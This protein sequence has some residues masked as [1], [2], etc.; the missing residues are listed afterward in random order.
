MAKTGKKKGPVLERKI[1]VN[2]DDPEEV[3]VCLLEGD[4]LEAYQVE[5]ETWL[6]TRGNIYKGRITNIEPGLQAVFVDIGRARNAYLPLDDI[7]PD[8]FG[9]PENG[10]RAPEL[11]HKG[12]EIL[13]QIVKEESAMKGAAVTTYLSIPG[14]FLVIMPGTDQV[15]VSRKIEEEA[16]R[17]RLKELLAELARPEGIGLIVRT[18]S[19]GMTKKEIKRDLSYLLRLW[20]DLKKKAQ[21]APTP[22]L[23]YAERD[24]VTRFLRD[25]LT[26][27]VT[28]IIIDDGAAC[29]DVRAFLKIISP[30]H[31]ATVRHYDGLKPI[32]SHYGVEVQIESIFRRRVELPSGGSLV[33][34]PT[35][36]LVA[37]DVNSGRL[38]HEKDFEEI[39]Y[40][41][42]LEAAEEIA[43]QLRL[44]DL[45]GII[46]VDFIDM[47]HRANRIDLE[48]R[49]KELLKKDKART[50]VSRIGPFGL[51]EIVRQK[52][53]APVQMAQHRA[54]PCCAGRGI[55][56]TVESLAVTH[57]RA[58]RE[59]LA[60]DHGE[61]M[62]VLIEVQPEVAFHILNAK[63]DVIARIEGHKG[64]RI[65]VVGNPGLGME[66]LRITK[67]AET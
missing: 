33:I 36:A 54:C 31:E 46:V 26:S 4:R 1:I 27:D 9:N 11:L 13:V 19:K 63:R 21:K 29:E 20:Q 52:I 57:L 66:E 6:K 37:I 15:G 12:Q 7:H 51:M 28:E 25:Y 58:L 2:M 24:L 14:R 18:V 53:G 56:R 41:T 62:K 5:S 65:H 34:E 3:R 55:V 38:I 42:N 8:Y 44:R 64:T 60:G 40:N 10:K 16:E 47:R 49:M 35:E 23:L 67:M 30:K 32:F 22:F 48:R 50:E 39:A 43:R 17:R 45:A 59:W 61:V